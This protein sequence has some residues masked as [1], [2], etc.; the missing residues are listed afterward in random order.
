[1][2]AGKRKSIPKSLRNKVW[3][4]TIGKQQG[5]GPCYCCKNEI[6]SKNFECGHIVAVKDGGTNTLNNLKPICATCNKSMGTQNLYRFKAIYFPEYQPL[7]RWYW[8][9]LGN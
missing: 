1:M 5:V 7:T 8:M 4:I 3:D 6:D 2:R 9:F